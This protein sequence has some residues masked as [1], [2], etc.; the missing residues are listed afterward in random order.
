MF[1]YISAHN[2]VATPRHWATQITPDRGWDERPECGQLYGMAR[3]QPTSTLYT[4]IYTFIISVKI[5]GMWRWGAGVWWPENCGVGGFAVSISQSYVCCDSVLSLESAEGVLP[6]IHILILTGF[7][8]P[9]PHP[10]FVGSTLFDRA[11]CT[12]LCYLF[13]MPFTKYIGQ[14]CYLCYAMWCTY[15]SAHIFR[16]GCLA[17]EKIVSKLDREMRCSAL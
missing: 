14:I 15:Y 6:I 17:W 7:F 13:A 11:T 3:T 10:D 2:Q 12:T 4:N 9:A 1:V 16:I 5:I 8:P